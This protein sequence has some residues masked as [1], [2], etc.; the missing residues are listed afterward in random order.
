MSHDLEGG[1]KKA[2]LKA[3]R[4]EGRKTGRQNGMNEG[5]REEG[6]AGRDETMEHRNDRVDGMDEMMEKMQ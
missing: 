3:G 2:H 5:R 6:R 4:K 1:R